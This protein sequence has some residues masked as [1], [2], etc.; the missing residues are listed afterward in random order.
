MSA[1]T[2]PTATQ[3]PGHQ[4]PAYMPRLVDRAAMLMCAQWPTHQVRFDW[5]ADGEDRQ[6]IGR[7]AWDRE[8]PAPRLVVHDGRSGEFICRSLPGQPFE[9]DPTTWHI[10]VADD[11]LDRFEWNRQRQQGQDRTRASQRQP[12]GLVK[13]GQQP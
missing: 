13:Q 2:T 10:D 12:I 6:Y 11:E 7:L 9:I 1:A 5:W 3:A 8:D 4:V